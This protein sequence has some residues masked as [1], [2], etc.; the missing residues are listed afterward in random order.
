MS[1]VIGIMSVFSM[2]LHP[3]IEITWRAKEIMESNILA[4]HVL[5]SDN[6]LN[7]AISCWY[8]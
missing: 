8:T 7:V 1:S 6:E 5:D 4:Y 3:K 2:F